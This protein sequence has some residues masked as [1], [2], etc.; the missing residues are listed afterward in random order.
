MFLQCVVCSSV[1]QDEI[2]KENLRLVDWQ[3][4]EHGGGSPHTFTIEDYEMLTSSDKLFARKF[5]PDVDR[6]II[7]A[8]YARLEEAK[9]E[10]CN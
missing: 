1:H 6:E 2:V 4:T 3:R 9:P 5:D 8:L 10:N 7:D